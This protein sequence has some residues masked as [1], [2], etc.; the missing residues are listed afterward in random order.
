MYMYEQKKRTVTVFVKQQ[1][2][3]NDPNRKNKILQEIKNVKA[4]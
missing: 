3:E 1:G 4:N 2:L